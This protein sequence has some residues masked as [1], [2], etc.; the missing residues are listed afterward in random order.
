MNT[1]VTDRPSDYRRLVRFV[2]SPGPRF[3]LALARCATTELRDRVMAQ[4]TQAVEAGGG[5]I[6]HL[7]LQAHPPGTNL[8]ANFVQACKPVGGRSPKALF[9]RNLDSLLT[10]ALRQPRF[11]P[12]VEGLN[13]VRDTLPAM[14]NARVV[15]FLHDAG[16]DALAQQAR[17]LF[18]VVQTTFR[19]DEQAAPRAMGRRPHA[20]RGMVFTEGSADEIRYLEAT[21]DDAE[22][23]PARVVRAAQ[24][25]ARLQLEHGALDPARELVERALRIQDTLRDGDELTRAL[26]LRDLARVHAASGG[27]D[28]AF[29]VFEQALAG[30]ERA[31]STREAAVTQIEIA[32]LHERRGAF[33][34]ALAVLEKQLPVFE[35]L[36]LRRSRATVLGEMARMELQRGRIERARELYEEEIRAYERLGDTIAEAEALADLAAVYRA[37]GLSDRACALYQEALELRELTE[38]LRGELRA[39][40]E[41]ARWAWS[42]GAHEEALS[43]YEAVVHDALRQGRRLEAR[44]RPAHT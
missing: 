34:R 15:L 38:E 16:A 23:E 1:D 9:V 33:A 35:R 30:F 26:L 28:Q 14:V 19:F 21:L 13:R 11:T 40:W 10:D 39:R 7:D 41:R 42:A 44:P 6:A 18:D 22:A 27:E 29:E 32:R 24:R 43:L 2:S 36:G 5:R 3:G 25:L 17:D 12:A 37:D 8:L 4:A 31:R 20:R